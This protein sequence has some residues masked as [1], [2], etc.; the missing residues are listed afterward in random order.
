MSF[1]T[2]NFPGQGLP[3]NQIT[4]DMSENSADDQYIDC[5]PKREDELKNSEKLPLPE[6]YVETWEKAKSHWNS[7]GQ[8][9]GSFN[10]IY[11]I[12]I[13]AYTVGDHLYRD[14]N[15]AAREAGKSQDSYEQYAFKDFHLL[16]TKALQAKKKTSD[17]YEVFRGIKNIHFATS[18]KAYVRFGHFASSSLDKKGAQGFGEDTFFSIKTCYGVPI[19][20]FSFHEKQKEILIPPYE[21]FTVTNYTKTQKGIFIRLE[22]LKVYSHFNCEVLKDAGLSTAMGMPFLLWGLLLTWT[23]L[24]SLGNL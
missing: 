13:V 2:F 21:T 7:L 6:K 15:T 8:T 10:R 24:G 18:D 11:G 14:F 1:L 19:H 4:L 20:D 17:C 12:V 23:T 5:N 16:L 3:S 9:V 22:S